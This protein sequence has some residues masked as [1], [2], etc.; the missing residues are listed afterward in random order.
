[1]L[2]KFYENQQF[3][4]ICI[5]LFKSAPPIGSQREVMD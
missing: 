1:M 2:R 5:D 4:I 3:S